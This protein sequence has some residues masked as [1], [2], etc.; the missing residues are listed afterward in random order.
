[1]GGRGMAYITRNDMRQGFPFNYDDEVENDPETEIKTSVFEK[2]K[3]LHISTRSSTDEMDD[4]VL[5]QQSNIVYDIAKKYNKILKYG[6]KTTEM[7]FQKKERVRGIAAVTPFIKDN[8]LALR[9]YMNNDYF[10]NTDYNS[11]DDFSKVIE[12]NIDSGWFA[13]INKINTRKYIL[14]HEM[15]HVIE[16]NIIWKIAKD[17]NIQWRG[18]SFMGEQSFEIATKIKNEVIKIWK[19]KYTNKSKDD[20]IEIS[21]YSKAHYRNYPDHRPFEWFAET[22]ANLQLADEPAPIAKALDEYIRGYM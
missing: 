20:I 9:L 4:M 10:K 5:E 21:N 11:K 15:G 13:P 2:L 7:M 1:M 14:T 22:F 8:E 17:K 12:R 19:E 18:N 6:T 3:K 16:S